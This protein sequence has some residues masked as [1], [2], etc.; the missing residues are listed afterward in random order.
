MSVP[1]GW[2]L[3]EHATE[4]WQFKRYVSTFRLGRQRI[5]PD[6]WHVM[7]TAFGVGVSC[8]DG[9]KEGF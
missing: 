3:D 9:G 7:V 6:R 1:T 4:S 5:D 8:M 2:Q